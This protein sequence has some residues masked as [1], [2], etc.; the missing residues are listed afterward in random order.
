MTILGTSPDTGW[1]YQLLTWAGVSSGTAEHWQHVVLRPLTVVL[2]LLVGALCAWA[3][4]HVI[5]RWIGT[6]VRRAAAK[7]ESSRA[8]QRAVTL[9]AMVANIWRVAVALIA[10][11]V[12]LGTIGINLTPL[13]AGATIVGATIGFGAQRIILDVLAG[14]LLGVEGQYDIG[15]TI[16]VN[17]PAPV[18]GVV[19]DLSLRVTRVRAADGAVWFLCNGDIRAAANTTRGWA[20]AS[21]DVSVPPATDVAMLLRVLQE[22]GESFYGDDQYH[23]SCSSAPVVMGMVSSTP[24][25][26]TARVTVRTTPSSRPRLEHGLR[27]EA[28][29]RLQE[30]GVFAPSSA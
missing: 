8:E 30:A 17:T 16:Q 28:L 26:I 15:D 5:R 6:A 9:T 25:S 12:A 3:G 4:N 18:V 21:V 7:A 1:L 20:L 10:V 23:H 19:E 27:E 13:L 11:L 29:K 14:F 24:E 2:V 22:A